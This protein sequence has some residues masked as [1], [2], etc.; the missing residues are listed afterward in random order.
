[1][2]ALLII[3]LQFLLLKQRI[4]KGFCFQ[5]VKKFPPPAEIGVIRK[6]PLL[7]KVGMK[8]GGFLIRGGFLNTNTSDSIVF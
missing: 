1:M 6:P 4:S 7:L 5:K 8:R 3:F 2:F